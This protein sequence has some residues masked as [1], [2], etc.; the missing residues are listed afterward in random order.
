MPELHARLTDEIAAV[1]KHVEGRLKLLGPDREQRGRGPARAKDTDRLV[2]LIIELKRLGVGDG[3]LDKLEFVNSCGTVLGLEPRFWR[4]AVER[5]GT[6]VHCLDA[7]LIERRRMEL[8]NH[9]SET[10]VCVGSAANI[11]LLR[12]VSQTVRK[13]P[14]WLREFLGHVVRSEP[15]VLDESNE[16]VLHRLRVRY[17]EVAERLHFTVT[18]K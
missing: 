13:P 15:L 3:L 8:E 16:K 17:P 14:V 11:A 18:M 12:A 6:A 10:D 9:L 1:A 7:E 4:E 5:L 2:A